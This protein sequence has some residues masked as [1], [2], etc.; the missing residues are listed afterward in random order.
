MVGENEPESPTPPQTLP[1]SGPDLADVPPAPTVMLEKTYGEREKTRDKG[2]S[3][4][5]D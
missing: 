5:R 1:T 4:K 3:E 2:S